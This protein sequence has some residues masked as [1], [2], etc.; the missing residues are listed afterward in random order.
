[1]RERIEL[2][3]L[4][5]QLNKLKCRIFLREKHL[6]APAAMRLVLS[7]LRFSS[8][9]ML[10]SL[11]FVDRRGGVNRKVCKYLALEAGK[12]SAHAASYP[13]EESLPDVGDVSSI[14]S[15][16]QKQSTSFPNFKVPL[17]EPNQPANTNLLDLTKIG[18]PF[19]PAG[20]I[21]LLLCKKKNQNQW[22]INCSFVTD[23]MT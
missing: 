10:V 4:V 14:L 20:A 11:G 7:N 6:K 16:F 9:S 5:L 2:R 15:S 22:R 1:M 21:S 17:P 8:S 12:D 19:D 18:V 23:N 13:E 3:K